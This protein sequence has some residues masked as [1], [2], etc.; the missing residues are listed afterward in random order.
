[1]WKRTLESYETM[2]DEEKHEIVGCMS[3]PKSDASIVNH[4]P[5][6]KAII[7][8]SLQVWKIHTLKNV[9]KAEHGTIEKLIVHMNPIV[10]FK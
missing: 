10:S 8:W 4:G 5:H 6:V 9:L 1:M 2:F 7:R 3:N